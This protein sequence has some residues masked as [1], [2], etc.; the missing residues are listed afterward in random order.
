[1][2]EQKRNLYTDSFN[3]VNKNIRSWF[4]LWSCITII[5]ILL[6]W[7]WSGIPEW[8]SIIEHGNIAIFLIA[9]S[10]IHRH[11]FLKGLFFITGFL[12]LITFFMRLGL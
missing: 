7:F 5:L 11:M 9:L 8:L 6:V 12:S 1:M 2:K 10:F 4:D 3:S